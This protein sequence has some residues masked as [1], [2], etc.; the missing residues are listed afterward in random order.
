MKARGIGR[1]NG[2]KIIVTQDYVND[3]YSRPFVT[4]P[5]VAR[6]LGITTATVREHIRKKVLPG[7]LMP[8]GTTVVPTESFKVY[9]VNKR[10]EFQDRLYRLKMPEYGN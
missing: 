1:R 7:K 3:V 8:D 4:I 2:E 6:M 9:V 5:D 10:K